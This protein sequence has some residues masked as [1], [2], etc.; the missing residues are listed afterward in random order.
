MEV[1]EE[2]CEREYDR[3][4][5]FVLGNEPGR[6]REGLVQYRECLPRLVAMDARRGGE[7]VQ[8]AL[9]QDDGECARL[10]L[11]SGFGV[12][13]AKRGRYAE[14]YRDELSDPSHRSIFKV[15]A[16]MRAFIE[17]L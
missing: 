9:A 2:E 11:S 14:G 6:L 3:L 15:S 5:G 10:L 13:G 12:Q 8:N 7:M 16:K 1:D 4:M 17:S